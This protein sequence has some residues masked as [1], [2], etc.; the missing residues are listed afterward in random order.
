MGWGEGSKTW[1]WNIMAEEKVS[2]QRDGLAY[3]P[4]SLSYQAAPP[5]HT[6]IPYNFQICQG[7]SL[8]ITPHRKHQGTKV[9]RQEDLAKIEFL[10]C[11]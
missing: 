2:R 9:K 11:K 8:N 6:S 5:H 1:G 7:S 10:N 3:K 4:P